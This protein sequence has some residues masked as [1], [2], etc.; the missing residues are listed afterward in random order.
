MIIRDVFIDDP[1][2]PDHLLCTICL[3]KPRLDLI[4][5]QT[6]I[7]IVIDPRAFMGNQ[8]SMTIMV[9]SARFTHDVT[10]DHVKPEDCRNACRNLTITV[11][12]LF[13]TPAIKGYV[14]DHKCV[15]SCFGEKRTR[16]PT[17]EI[18]GWYIPKRD[19]F[20]NKLADR[21][22]VFFCRQH[23]NGFEV[24]Y[25]VGNGGNGLLNIGKKVQILIDIPIHRPLHESAFMS[26]LFR[27]HIESHLW[28]GD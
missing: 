3:Q 16:I 5:R 25:F 23:V 13:I 2:S 4:T 1:R 19:I 22:V 17:P 10:I 9:N 26:G 6:W 12:N 11:M 21:R 15:G 8:Q 14:T 18:L 20:R 24:G 27:R 28:S 7:A